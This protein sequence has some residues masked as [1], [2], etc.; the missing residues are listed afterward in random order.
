MQHFSIKQ[1]DFT[2]FYLVPSI[3]AG[4]IFGLMSKKGISSFWAIFVAAVIQTGLSFAFIPLTTLI[5]EINFID[6]LKDLLK[7]LAC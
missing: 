5:T 3:I 6:L 2:L 1:V 7:F 4:Y